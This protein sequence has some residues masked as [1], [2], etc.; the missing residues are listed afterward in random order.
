[1]TF[2]DTAGTRF[3]VV[4]DEMLIAVLI[5][6]ALLEMGCEIAGLVGKLDAAM[7]LADTGE[8][9]AAILDVT[10]RGG[11]IY[12]VAERLVARGIP[13]AFSSGYGDWALPESLRNRPRLMKPFTLTAFQEQVRALCKEA[14]GTKQGLPNA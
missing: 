8:F 13:F 3:L 1:M 12:P 10:V 5:E 4:E 9:D 6:D 2:S 11:K 7:Q 14:A